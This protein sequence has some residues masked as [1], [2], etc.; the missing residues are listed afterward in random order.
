MTVQGNLGKIYLEDDE[1]CNI[2]GKWDVQINQSNGTMLQLKDVRHVPN[3]KR[4]FVSVGQLAD[5]GYKTTFID[6]S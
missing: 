5:S 1:L 6:D 2:I 4:N 3:L